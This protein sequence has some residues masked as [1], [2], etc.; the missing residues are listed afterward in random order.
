MS[1][2]LNHTAIPA[3]A[4]ILDKPDPNFAFGTSIGYFT[5]DGTTTKNLAPPSFHRL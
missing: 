2:F 5:T 3:L 4:A 1:S